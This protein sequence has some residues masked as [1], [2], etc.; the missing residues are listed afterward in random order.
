MRHPAA[1]EERREEDTEE[2]ERNSVGKDRGKMRGRY[3]KVWR[4]KE[5]NHHE[6]A[7]YHEGAFGDGMDA[8]PD[9]VH[10]EKAGGVGNRGS[11]SPKHAD[12]EGKAAALPITPAPST[13]PARTI[14]MERRRRR[15]GFSRRITHSASVPS[16]MDWKRKMTA[17]EAGRVSSAWL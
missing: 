5:E 7:A 17:S 4:Q 9:A 16:Q 15:V 13:V 12:G 3:R 11:K 10:A 8:S 1:K 2:G 6:R 14:A